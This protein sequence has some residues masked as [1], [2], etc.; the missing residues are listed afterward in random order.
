MNRVNRLQSERVRAVLDRLFAAAAIDSE[1]HIDRPLAEMSSQE[2]AD[3]LATQYMPISEAGGK[4]LYGMIRSART[5]TVVEFGTSFAISTIYL[6]SA[7]ADNG[8]G[9]VYTTEMSLA[10][11]ETARAN[12]AEAGLAEYVTVLAGDA[13]QTLAG[14]AGPIGIVL[15]DG[16]KDLYVPVLKSIEE[17]LAPGALVV[18][19]DSTFPSMAGYLAYIRDPANGYV[20]VD[21][22]VED[23]MEIS[24]RA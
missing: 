16:W 18:A 2:R 19:D 11:V 1:S 7:V 22:P 12:L 21:F 15:L 14:I 8:A 17:R 23:G 9:H 4:L 10:K 3:A 13:L 5:A 6:A 24:C 20:S